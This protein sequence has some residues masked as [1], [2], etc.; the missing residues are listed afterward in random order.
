MKLTISGMSE[1]LGIPIALFIL[2][3]N[4]FGFGFT[5]RINVVGSKC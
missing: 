1:N 3:I 2:D 5:R 4:D